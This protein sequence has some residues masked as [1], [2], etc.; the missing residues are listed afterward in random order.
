MVFDKE[1]RFVNG[2]TRDDFQLRVDGQLVPIQAFDLIKQVPIRKH[3]SP[4]AEI[5]IQV[6]QIQRRQSCLIAAERFCFISMTF[7]ST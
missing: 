1:G 3:D 7:I 2:L 6:P 5:P 4:A